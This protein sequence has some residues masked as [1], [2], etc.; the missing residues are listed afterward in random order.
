MDTLDSS[1]Y[2]SNDDLHMLGNGTWYRSYDKLG[3]HPAS[4]DGADGYHFAVWAPNVRS[5]SVIGDFNDWDESAFYLS[6][7]S[8]GDVWE[9]FIPGVKAGQLY[10]YLLVSHDGEKIYKADPYAF[11]SELPPGTASIT[12]DISGY[13]WKDGDYMAERANRPLLKSPLN[14]FEVHLG[15]WKRHGNE[16]QGE[17]REDGTWP[18]PGDPFPAQRGT[19]YSYDDLSR[20]LVAYVKKM[21]YSHIEVLPLSEHPFDGSWGYQSTGYYAPTSRYGN[22]KQLMHFIDACHKAGIGVIMDWVPG[23]FCADAHGLA[24][25]NGEMLYEHEIHPNWG[26]HKFDFSRGQVRSFLVSNALYWV[27]TYH[28]DGIR[29][30]GVSSMLYMNFG[31]DNPGQKRFNKYGTEEALDASAFIRQT[32]STMGQLHPDVMMIAEESTAWPL[33]TYP[34][35]DGGLGFH[36]KW[37]MG[38]MND[39]LHYMQT[40]FPWRPGN[41]RLLTF[42]TMYQFNENF[43]LPL[44]H[45]EVVNGKCSLVTRMPGDQ[46]RQFAGLRSLAFYQMMH[47]GGKLNF[48]GNE[49]GQYIEWRYYEGIEYFLADNYET[50]RKQQ[51]FVEALNK[52]YKKNPALW[53]R[54]YESSGFEWLDADNSDQSIISFIRRGDDPKDDL[55]IL[56]NFDVNAREDFRLGVPEWGVYAEKFNSDAAEF[57][58]SG[59]LNEG[60][61]RCEDVAWNGR[62]QSVV[63]RI[64]PLAGIVL[65][66]VANQAKPKP[67]SGKAA[68]PAKKAAAPAKKPAA[69]TA[70]AKAT[71]AKKPAAKAAAKPTATKT[72]PAAAQKPKATEKP[73]AKAEAKA[74]SKPA[75]KPA[76]VKKTVKASSKTK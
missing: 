5:V 35:E 36:F 45:D 66:K 27:E 73:T 64:P 21:G 71:P 8:S 15:S 60:R 61:L 9:G 72:E 74:P 50:H 53:Q 54:G 46:W 6:R 37:D 69:K 29:M 68:A 34:P 59:V 1:L 23:G 32:N 65:K 57:G 41:H 67:A 70:A 26:T 19:Y 63:L 25:F 47:A 20:E 38:W 55:V 42:S 44:S 40:D 12:A 51:V 56:I 17:P 4:A 7:S 10:K 49:I 30:D 43:V 2:L 76:A 33:V 13:A 39:T 14:I 22:P 58:G 48:M 75:K 18:G 24:S 28:I 52:F 16:P 31:I 3:A 11:F 62:E